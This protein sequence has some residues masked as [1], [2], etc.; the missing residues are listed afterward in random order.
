MS[1]KIFVID[2]SNVNIKY[3]GQGYIKKKY[4]CYMLM[5]ICTGVKCKF[6]WTER[7]YGKV[8]GKEKD[9]TNII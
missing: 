3:Q 8:L 5:Y 9:M 1:K 7:I 6:T 4:Q 2:M